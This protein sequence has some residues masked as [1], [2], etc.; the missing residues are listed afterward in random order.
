MTTGLE[1][2]QSINI[3]LYY[4]GFQMSVTKR[5]QEIEVKGLIEEAMRGIDWAISQGL[6]PSW[7]EETNKEALKDQEVVKPVQQKA[8]PVEQFQETCDRCGAKKIMS[9]KGNM[10]CSKYCWTKNK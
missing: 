8:L 2:P 7:N 1:S 3:T 4:K 6:K 5:D 9:K 10:V